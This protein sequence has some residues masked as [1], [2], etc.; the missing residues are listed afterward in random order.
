MKHAFVLMADT[1]TMIYGE[2]CEFA[3][4]KLWAPAYTE[5]FT[6]STRI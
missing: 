3:T 1:V 5:L 6:Y 2:I 4:F